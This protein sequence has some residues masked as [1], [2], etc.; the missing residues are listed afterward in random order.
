MNDED[1]DLPSEAWLRE[2]QA[3]E[4]AMQAD[5]AIP[6]NRFVLYLDPHRT[7]PMLFRYVPPT[8]GNFWIGATNA[9]YYSIDEICWDSEPITQIEIPYGFWMATFPTTQWQWETIEALM[10]KSTP[11]KSHFRGRYRPMESISWDECQEWLF[12]LNNQQHVQEQL[13]R[14]NQASALGENHEQDISNHRWRI[15]LPAEAHWE[16]ACRATEAKGGATE[17]VTGMSEYHAGDGTTALQRCGW[18]SDNSGQHTHRVGEKESNALGLYDMHGNVWE[19]CED[20]WMPNYSH[21]TNG[22]SVME[23]VEVSQL[24]GNQSRRVVR[25]G[26]WDYSAG[27]CR[28]AF[29]D[30][31]WPGGR[32]GDRGVRVGLF[33]GPI[34]AQ[35]SKTQAGSMQRRD[36][37]TLREPAES[38][39]AGFS[40]MSF[41]P[42]SGEKS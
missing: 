26:C 18:Y 39:R 29:R 32:N 35:A 10:G 22:M 5:K 37:E 1:P 12:T 9:E 8:Q 4:Q 23:M 33:S 24:E 21:L 19:W 13:R 36:A 20:F 40:S 11:S 38:K 28:S 41:P 14:L 15:G 34:R 3:T 27:C 25:G 30:W 16:W 17:W 42:R 2:L 7:V 6:S 31:W